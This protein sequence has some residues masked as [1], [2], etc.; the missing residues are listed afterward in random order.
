MREI[1]TKDISI[2]CFFCGRTIFYPNVRVYI[3]TT[4]D[5]VIKAFCNYCKDGFE[6]TYERR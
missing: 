6:K 5:I 1:L 2:A 3:K 4:D